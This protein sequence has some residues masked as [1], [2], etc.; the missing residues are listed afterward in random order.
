MTVQTVGLILLACLF[1]GMLLGT[2]WTVQAVQ[3]NL[4]RQAEER[5]RLNA[6]WHAIG[7]Q[8]DQ[9]LANTES[10]P[11]VQLTLPITLYTSDESAH[12]QV[13]SAVEDLLTAA[14]GH[15]EFRN[16]SGCGSVFR[17]MQ[18]KFSNVADSPLGDEVTNLATHA[19]QSYLVDA[20]DAVAT[21]TLLQNLGSVLVA[22][23]PTKKAV[24]RIGALL[25][26]KIDSALVVH[27]LTPTQQLQ[28]NHQPQ[29]A[30]SPH[31]ILY[32]LELRPGS[33]S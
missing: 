3:P 14:G 11:L 32:A 30:Q 29:L 17:G 21:V 12:K 19:V 9:T 27:Q 7:Q 20:R 2:A 25:I 24:I 22:L 13:E 10:D 5:R 31:Q 33:S 8:Q 23:Q 16:D 4:R 26:V 28:R 1:I 6:A 18:A 15:L